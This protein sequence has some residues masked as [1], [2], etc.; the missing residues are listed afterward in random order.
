MFSLF[1]NLYE[2][3]IVAISRYYDFINV[4]L[5]V[6]AITILVS[7]I[8][9]L[10]IDIVFWSRKAYRKLFAKSAPQV[11]VSTLMANTEKPAAIM[12]PA[13]KEFDVIEQM[14]ETNLKYVNYKNYVFFVGV[15]QNDHQTIAEVDKLVAKHPTVKKVVVPHDGPTCKADCLNW[16]IKSIFLYEIQINTKFEMVIMHDS[17]DVIH[18][19]ELKMFNHFVS[20][21]DL[22]QIP[23]RGLT[24]KWN[25]FV[26]G[27]YVDEFAEHHGKELPVREMLAKIVPSAGVS[28]CFSRRAI[29]ILQEDNEQQIFNTS[30]LTED[31][32]ISYR[33]HRANKLLS[34]SERPIKQ[35]FITF[36]VSTSFTK[37][38]PGSHNERAEKKVPIACSEYFPSRVWFSI[39]QKTRWNI[40]IFYQAAS[41]DTW[42]AGN[43]WTKYFF[44]HERKGIITN[45]MMLPTYFLVLNILAFRLGEHYL[46]LPAYVFDLPAWLLTANLVLMTNRAIQ[47]CYFTT[48]LYDWQEGIF[49]IPR[50]IISNI[51]NFC[52]TC[53]ATW[54]YAGHL[55][56]K[57]RIAWDKTTHEFPSTSVLGANQGLLG[58]MLVER[59]IISEGVL[60]IALEKKKNSTK[61]LEQIL[62]EEKHISVNALL[63]VLAA[64]ASYVK[65]GD[66]YTAKAA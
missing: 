60:Q 51:I 26:R 45:I 35:N 2:L 31:Y 19:L 25:D 58:D 16:I 11:S 44:I 1:E 10:F 37:H 18:P 48:T 30:S 54:I 40:G 53:R 61:T 21:N 50:T 8:D 5:F 63:D 65:K 62:L 59:G 12:V 49:S 15:Y 14:I 28:T 33:L 32:D 56:T 6:T 57:K 47:R 22:I 46:G 23:V 66:A 20:Q 52:S 13:W 64:Q 17:E 24:S 4:I 3:D 39:R 27:S 38:I 55:I 9:D 7:S 34:K 36:P 29:L 42:R 43:F 41:L